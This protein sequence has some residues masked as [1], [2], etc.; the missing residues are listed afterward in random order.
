MMVDSTRAL[1]CGEAARGTLLDTDATVLSD[2]GTLAAGDRSGI[3]EGDRVPSEFSFV[4]SKLL[5]DVAAALAAIAAEGV[6]D[7]LFGRILG[8]YGLAALFLAIA[9]SRL[10]ATLSAVESSMTVKDEAGAGEEGRD[11]NLEC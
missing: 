8:I 11:G 4:L 2:V 10:R 7:C 1:G 5:A 6:K 9:S 3:A